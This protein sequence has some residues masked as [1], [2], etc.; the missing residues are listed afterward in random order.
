MRQ[1]PPTPLPHPASLRRPVASSLRRSPSPLRHSP[2]Y[3]SV[4][5][6]LR[7]S[8]PPSPQSPVP[9][10]I[11]KAF[12]LI[13]LLVVI[14]IIAVL[15]GILM[16]ALGAARSAA[17]RTQCLVNLRSMQLGLTMYLDQESKGLLPE[18]LP[19]VE[20]PDFGDGF[21]N[22]NDPSLLNILV[23]YID[24]PLPTR[25][26]D[27]PGPEDERPWIV[28]HP[29]KCPEDRS[30][31]D[32][33]ENGRAVH[34][35]F[36]TSYAYLPGLVMLALEFTG[37]ASA[38]ELSRPVTRVWTD[39]VDSRKRPLDLPVLYDADDWHPRGSGDPRLASY[40]DGHADWI[41]PGIQDTVFEDI[42][43]QAARNAGLGG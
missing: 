18:V 12:T 29:Y 32:Q 15:I 43:I 19:I 1:P 8:P 39:F 30:S 10:P 35:S 17:R 3:H 37:A 21:V 31:D 13:E 41:L 16:P 11:P 22:P 28:E 34:E 36:G 38:G 6:S 42:I 25:D 33:E 20:P 40:L 14:A 7:L 24:A 5:P 2:S 27:A 4:S 23:R 9:S 26:P